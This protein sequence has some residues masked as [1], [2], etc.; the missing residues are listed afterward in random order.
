M[1][2]DTVVRARIDSET[3]RKATKVLTEMGL[4]VSDA[5]R[6]LLVRVAA[7]KSL[8]F[9]V[10]VPNAETIAAMEEARR[11]N[12]RSFKTVEELLAELNEED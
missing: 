5:I 7:E 9:N 10:Q 3:K 1:A 4:S 12:L 6:L 8:P 2:A 11:G